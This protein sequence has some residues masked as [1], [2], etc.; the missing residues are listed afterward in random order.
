LNRLSVA[1]P[2]ATTHKLDHPY[3][4]QSAQCCRER[5]AQT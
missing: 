4:G 1:K 3:H 2:R 5:C